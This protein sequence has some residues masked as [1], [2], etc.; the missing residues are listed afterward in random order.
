[1]LRLSLFLLVV[2]SMGQNVWAKNFHNS[3]IRFEMPDRWQCELQKKAYLCRH[4]VS[5]SCKVN[6]TTAECKQQIKKSREAVIVLSAKEKSD[7]D[8]LKAFQNYFGSS[9]KFNASGATSQSKVIHNKIVSIKKHKWV[10]T[11]QLGRELPHY[12]TRYLATTKGN[13][14]V[15]VSFT[16]HKLYYTNYSNHFFEG[17]KSLEVLTDSLSSVN[18]QELG[19]KL[20]SRPIDIPEELLESTATSQTN[21]GDGAS[22]LMF[23]MSMLL[24]AA[25]LFIWFKSKKAS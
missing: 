21:S 7:V 17:I 2:I 23:F 9:R 13:V 20:L 10:D 5:K 22:S 4:R 24:A 15:L 8:N 16:A 12:Y 1:M 3:Y 14:A 25:G 18:Q 6:P 11:M 19:Q